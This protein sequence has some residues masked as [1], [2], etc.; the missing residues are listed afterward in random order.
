MHSFAPDPV[1]AS[2]CAWT[3]PSTGTPGSRSQSM[4]SV[5]PGS[6]G[7]PGSPTRSSTAFSCSRD[8]AS[9]PKVEYSFQLLP[10]ESS[11]AVIDDG[12]ILGLEG[13][14]YRD[15][16]NRPLPTSYE[17]SKAAR[18]SPP[19]LGKREGELNRR[20]RDSEE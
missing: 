19:Q 17:G 10:G 15:F 9:T 5:A 7:T 12:E 6:A 11:S 20:R 1:D 16:F 18:G 2:F 4:H 3:P 14:N 13:Q 8:S